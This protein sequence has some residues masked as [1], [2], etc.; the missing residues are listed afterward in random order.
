MTW[1]MNRPLWRSLLF[2]PANNEKYVG[3]AAASGADAC[4]LDLEDS[5]APAQKAAARAVVADAIRRLSSEGVAVLV[6]VNSESLRDDIAAAVGVG[7]R[8]LVLPKVASAQTI[9]EA[10]RVVGELEQ[11]AGLAPGGIALVAQIESVSALPRLDEIAAASSRLLAMSLGPEDF[12]T[13]AGMKPTLETLYWPSQQVLFACRRA[14]ILPLGYPLS[15]AVYRDEALLEK[16][17]GLARDMGF[18]GA[19]CIH[20]GQVGILNRIFTPGEGGVAEAE[21]LLQAYQEE[22]AAGRGTFSFRGR[23]VDAPIVARAEEIL[24]RDRA[25]KLLSGRARKGN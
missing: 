15:I 1:T 22:L 12:S 17:V 9:V 11:Y 8:A 3:R 25:S 20:P 19:F 23:M 7:L 24:A 5:I 13:S 18:V 10:D 6:R 21:A 14:G 4:V 16:A 2:V